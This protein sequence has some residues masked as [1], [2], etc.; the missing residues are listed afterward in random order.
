MNIMLEIVGFILNREISVNDF[1]SEPK[2]TSYC[3]TLVGPPSGSAF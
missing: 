3:D 2:I 1:L